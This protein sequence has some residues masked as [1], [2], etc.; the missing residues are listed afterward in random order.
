MIHSEGQTQRRPK[1]ALGA[2]KTHAIWGLPNAFDRGTKS[3][4]AHKWGLDNP[5]RVGVPKF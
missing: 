2:Y 4:V 5:C 1:S 3:E